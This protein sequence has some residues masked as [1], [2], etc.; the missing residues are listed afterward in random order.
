MISAV[1]HDLRAPLTVI[2]G[3]ATLLLQTQGELE[4][5]RA[6]E[7]LRL[8]D[9]QVELMNDRI[10]DM[11]AIAA[12]DAGQLRLSHERLAL[13]ELVTALGAWAAKRDGG[14]RV[15]VRADPDLSPRGDPGPVLEGDP[16]RVLQCLRALVRNALR[17]CPGDSP[18][19]VSMVA[20][21]TGGVCFRVHDRGPGLPSQVT[22][23]Q[24]FQSG[25][26]G[27]GLGLDL[28][29]GLVVAMGGE[30]AYEARP[31]GGS[32]LSFTL[33]GHA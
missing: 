7:M 16:D 12:L 26:S 1:G 3:A 28:V 6:A 21:G 2:R 9:G 19:E 14:T 29:R 22:P 5:G 4:P 24:R 13:E 11:L 17:H 33:G 30:V 18:I 8:I 23:F 10:E 20:D 31:G 27:A 15:S 32:A 25:G